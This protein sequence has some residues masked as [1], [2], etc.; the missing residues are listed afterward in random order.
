MAEVAVEEL[1]GKIPVV[2]GCTTFTPSQ[3]IALGLHA[4]SVRMVCCP[5][6]R[7]TSHHPS[8]A[9]KRNGRATAPLTAVPLQLPSDRWPDRNFAAGIAHP[10]LGVVGGLK[11]SQSENPVCFWISVRRSGSFE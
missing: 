5:R 10:V 8:P 7:R 9:A 4:K 3:T 1:G 2:V 11:L 6:L